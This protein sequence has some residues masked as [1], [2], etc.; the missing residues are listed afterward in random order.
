MTTLISKSNVKVKIDTDLVHPSWKIE[1]RNQLV[2]SIAIL[3]A[4]MAAKKKE[5]D[6]LRQY[7]VDEGLAQWK[8][9]KDG[10]DTPKA[11]DMAWWTTH[12]A[13]SFEKQCAATEDPKH[14]DHKSFWK[15]PSKTFAMI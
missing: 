1:A 10:K 12:R 3:E 9:S 13:A 7:A 4:D 5:R 14:P 11:P 15:K 8:L 2:A 6:T